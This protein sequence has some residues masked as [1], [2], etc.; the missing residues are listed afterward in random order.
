VS[1][2]EVPEQCWFCGN[3][4]EEK[5]ARFSPLRVS[6]WCKT[7]QK[8]GKKNIGLKISKRIWEM[9]WGWKGKKGR[10]GKVTLFWKR[11]CFFSSC[12]MAVHQLLHGAA[13]G[14]FSDMSD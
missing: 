4:K 2:A 7:H 9:V 14:S 12:A 11:G 8:V 6:P 3:F 10:V 13:L 1:A 5:G